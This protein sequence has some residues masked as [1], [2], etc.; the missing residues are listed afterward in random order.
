LTDPTPVRVCR[1]CSTQATTDGSFCPHC[2]K[3]YM[4]RRRRLGRRGKLIV[5]LASLLLLASGAATAVAMKIERDNEAQ[6]KRERAARLAADRR[7]AADREADQ[8]REEQELQDSL[9]AIERSSRRTLERSLERAVAKDARGLVTDGLLDG[10]ILSGSC[11]PVGGGRNDLDAQ[12]GKYECLAINEKMADGTARGYVYDGT[13][14]YD[15]F[16]YSWSLGR[17]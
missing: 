3:S 1:S 2:G 15:K 17:E 5:V 10:P 7:E 8:R 9:D 16:T 12:T 6:A 14:N 11:D 13:I 4:G